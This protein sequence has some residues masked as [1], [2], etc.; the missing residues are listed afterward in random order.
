MKIGVINGN[1]NE[2][3]SAQILGSARKAVSSECE[4]AA[5]TP[6]F[7]VPGVES[8][9]DGALASVGVCDAIAGHKKDFD[10]FVIAC[11]SDPG[12]FAARTICEVPVLG[13][14]QASMLTA[15]QIGSGFS[16]IS[17][18]PRIR[19]VLEDIVNRYCFQTFYN[20]TVT[21]PLT[22]SQ[23]VDSN[24]KK[25]DLLRKACKEALEQQ[26]S[27]VLILAGAVLAGLDEVLQS[28]LCVPV[29]DPVKCALTMAEG[30][31]RMRITHNHD[32]YFDAG[33]KPFRH[34]LRYLKKGS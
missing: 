34:E 10:A 28:E 29:L 6:E 33:E 25:L 19:G 30:L 27:D 23:S 4:V 18:Q 9:L 11:F 1:T 12:L 20:G 21:I 22:V 7:G 8:F 14:A 13:I 32:L 31:V 5:I 26:K 24:E 16:L 15:I 3:V 2:T 17:P